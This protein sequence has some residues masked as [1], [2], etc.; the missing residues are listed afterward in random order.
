MNL[1]P[2]V[3][4]VILVLS[5]F[6]TTQYQKMVTQKKEQ[7]IYTTY[8]R[9]LREA[10]NE[11]MR[12]TY[13]R[14]IERKRGP[15]KE[16]KGNQEGQIQTNY[17]REDRIGWEKGKLNLSSL[18]NDPEKWPGL[19]AIAIAYVKRLYIHTNFYPK[20]GGVEKKLIKAL[21]AK[22]K[23]EEPP[24][25]HKIRFEDRELDWL[26]YKMVKGTHTYDLEGK[27]SPPFANFFTFEETEGPPINFHYANP[28]LLKTVLG[29]GKAQKLFSEEKKYLAEAP[30]KCRSPLKRGRIQEILANRSAL[31]DSRYEK[32]NKTPG[33]HT[34]TTTQITVIAR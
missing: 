33:K 29:E 4:I 18:L 24:P 8:F 1:L 10:R 32:S 30:I 23:E 2:F 22:Y 25:F 21:V 34:D 7:K 6:S 16:T 31:F 17:F 3:M 9:G 28:S 15:K 27:G 20:S 5:L 13:N 12:H 14:S 11:K 26:F 19:E